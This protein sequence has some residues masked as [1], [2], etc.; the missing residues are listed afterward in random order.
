MKKLEE[1]LVASMKPSSRAAP[2]E[3]DAPAVTPQTVLERV[4]PPKARLQTAP[5]NLNDG[6][7]ALHPDRIWPD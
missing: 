6:D 1:K 4:S 7:C 2:L 3:K 5:A